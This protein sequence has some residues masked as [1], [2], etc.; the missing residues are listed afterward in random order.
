MSNAVHF[1]HLQ[2]PLGR[3]MIGF[4]SQGVSFAHFGEDT[5]HLITL[6]QRKHLGATLAPVTIEHTEVLESLA[7]AFDSLSRGKRAPID[8]CLN[9]TGTP[10]QRLVWAH[11]QS[12]PIGETKSYQAVA[13][14]LGIPRAVRA[15]AS[16]CARNDIA[17][18]IPCHRVIR[19]DGTM[20]GYRWGIERKKAL[21]AAEREV[22]TPCLLPGHQGDG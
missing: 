18:L 19:R 3:V 14:E 8:P 5:Y 7:L 10:F 17:L 21:L 4:S 6:L 13:S 11:L 9:V 20:G 22:S 16:A 2:S 1:C 15:V 12:I